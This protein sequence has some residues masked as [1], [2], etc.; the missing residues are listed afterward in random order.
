[1]YAAPEPGEVS[2]TTLTP[3]ESWLY[4]DGLECWR[5]SGIYPKGSSP[6]STSLFLL[7]WRWLLW[8]TLSCFLED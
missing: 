7:N 8:T 3:F 2:V 5:A 4:E 6:K 1:M